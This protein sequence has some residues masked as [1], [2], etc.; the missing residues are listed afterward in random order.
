MSCT[1]SYTFPCKEEF[2]PKRCVIKP[3]R[4]RCSAFLTLMPATHYILLPFAKI[5]L[6]LQ[7]SNVPDTLWTVTEIKEI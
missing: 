5:G 2:S 4:G 6:C 3:I 7:M 1:V